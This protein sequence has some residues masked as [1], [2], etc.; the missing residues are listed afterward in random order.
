[1]HLIRFCQQ[2]TTFLGIHLALDL[3]VENRFDQSLRFLYLLFNLL[4]LSHGFLPCG[5]HIH[6]P[7][8]YGVINIVERISEDYEQLSYVTYEI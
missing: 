2:D 6:I 1:V 7:L 3:I 8:H 5:D 4:I